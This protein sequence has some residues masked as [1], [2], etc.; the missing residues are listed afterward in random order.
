MR[1]LFTSTPLFG[2]FMP[3]LALIDAAM[4]AGHE[5]VVATG[6]DLADEVGRRGLPLWQ[7]GPSTAEVFGRRAALPELS[8]A[9]HIELLRRD[10]IAIFGWPGYQRARDL[11]PLAAEWRPDVVVHE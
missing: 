10:A 8:G 11:V 5:V 9:T 1:L 7:V 3:M 4:Q 2:H 6:P